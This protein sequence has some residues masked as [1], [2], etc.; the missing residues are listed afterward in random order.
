MGEGLA[1]LDVAEFDMAVEVLE[2]EASKVRELLIILSK[3]ISGVSIKVRRECETVT[4]GGG[5]NAR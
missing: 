2:T 4:G 3:V 1:V 5:A